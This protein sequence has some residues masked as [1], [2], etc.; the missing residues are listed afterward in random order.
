MGGIL[1]HVGLGL[2]VEEQTTMDTVESLS[3]RRLTKCPLTD[4]GVHV[5]VD[6]L[7]HRNT[8]SSGEGPFQKLLTVT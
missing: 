3:M 1:P 4:R 6:T 8:T 7:T 2:V 5:Y